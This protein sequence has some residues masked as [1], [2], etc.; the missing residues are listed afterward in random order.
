M[1]R[2]PKAPGT[3][4]A[5]PDLAREALKA[6]QL[7][8]VET[9]GRMIDELEAWGALYDD[10]V[11]AVRYAER[12]TPEDRRAAELLLAHLTIAPVD[13]HADGHRCECFAWLAHYFPE[14][15]PPV[16]PRPSTA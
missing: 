6:G 10:L 14:T 4:L 3:A 15:A 16:L 13:L 12:R 8:P 1:T 5:R 11:D 9:L 7:P 2:I